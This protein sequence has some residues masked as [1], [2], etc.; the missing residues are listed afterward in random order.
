MDTLRSLPLDGELPSPFLVVCRPFSPLAIELINE[1]WGPITIGIL[2]SVFGMG[3]FLVRHSLRS[4]PDECSF[5]LDADHR[6]L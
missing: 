3:I 5:F 6:I 1:Q 2:L 4:N